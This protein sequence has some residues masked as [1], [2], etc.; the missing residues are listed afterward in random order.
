[1]RN[2]NKKLSKTSE[3]LTSVNNG[4]K[5]ALANQK[6]N[7]IQHMTLVTSLTEEKGKLQ[8][9]LDKVEK[10]CKEKSNELKAESVIRL[11]R[12]KD[13]EDIKNL[14]EIEKQAHKATLTKLEEMKHE[15]TNNNVLS[16]EVA[17]YEVC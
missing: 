17:N 1:M 9:Q 11:Q 6:Q 8:T 14:L 3:N 5:D 7:S 10:K 4:L 2:E 12:I 16:L 13:Y 15:K